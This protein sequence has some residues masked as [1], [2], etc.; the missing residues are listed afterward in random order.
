MKYKEWIGL[1]L[2]NYVKPISKSKTSEC[3][4]SLINN[5]IK[6]HIGDYDLNEITPMIIQ[7]LSGR[8][9]NEGNE[10]T[11]GGLSPSTVNLIITIIQQSLNAAHAAGYVE[12]YTANNVKRPKMHEKRVECFDKTEQKLLEAAAIN[13]K[14]SK[15]IGVVLTL[16]TGLRIGEL[17]ALEWSDID[18]LNRTL[19]VN[20]TCSDSTDGAGGY[21]RAINA[22][23]TSSST[24][25]VP[26]PEQILFVLEGIKKKSKSSYVINEGNKVIPVRSYQ[27]SFELMLNSL[28]IK[29]RGFHSLRHTF[30]TRALECGMDVRT[31]AEI[32]GHK[33]P[34]VTLSRYAHS[35][36]EH[37][38]A[39]M[40]RLGEL[41][42]FCE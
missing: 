16:Y 14:K 39:M 27:R 30:A 12:H 18:F 20:K 6:K 33:N 41:F 35:L 9:L 26:I 3:Y 4:G 34:T 7:C 29:H 31:L 8:L 37:K 17:L 25:E 13:H 19:T 42:S 40:N 2:E 32:L 1:W 24:R 10:H 11:G 22:P 21:V 5:H 28:N 38:I 15:M 36:N 23:K